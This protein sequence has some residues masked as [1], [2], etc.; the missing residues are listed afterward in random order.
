VTAVHDLRQAVA[1]R[2]RV[3][4][5]LDTTDLPTA[6][7]PLQQVAYLVDVIEVGTILLLAEGLRAVRVIRALFPERPLLAD[8]RI[9]EAGGMIARMAFEAGASWVSVVAG[10]SL[11]TVEQV[12]L[13]AQKFEGEVQVEL[14]EGYDRRQAE[15][16]RDVGVRHVIVHR[17]RDAAAAGP[18]TWSAADLDRIDEL[19]ALGFTVTV[20]G[21]MTAAGLPVFA[22]HPVGIVIVGRAL[23]RAAS[24]LDTAEELRQAVAEVWP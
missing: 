12:C 4:I 3:Q 1:G 20:T 21:G 22:G 11:A 15:A 7:A 5:A 18:L 8:V 23:V 2:P 24:P 19:A 9:A 17:S 10:A 16:W 6:L 14:G 13:V